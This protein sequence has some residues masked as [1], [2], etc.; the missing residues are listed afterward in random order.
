MFLYTS[1][2]L[3]KATKLVQ[4]TTP[5]AVWTDPNLDVSFSKFD[6]LLVGSGGRGSVGSGGGGNGGGGAAMFYNRSLVP[7][8]LKEQGFEINIPSIY[9]TNARFRIL[10]VES[11]I[12]GGI[13]GGD[14]SNSG[15][16]GNGYSIGKPGA[17]GGGG[18]YRT[19]RVGS[20]GGGVN[21]SGRDVNVG[22]GGLGV[23]SSNPTT[24]NQT[25]YHGGSGDVFGGG[26]GGI[27]PATTLLQIPLFALGGTGKGGDGFVDDVVHYGQG[28]GGGSYGDGGGASNPNGGYGAGGAGSTNQMHI[29]YEGG[30]G[31]AVLY[32]HS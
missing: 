23:S 7:S 11:N 31:I 8:E 9:S 13:S 27:N 15:R 30:Q 5:T 4:I 18:G 28:G 22:T 12:G 32:Y 3:T 21:D 25:S 19:Y 10:G 26:K 14:G 6:F 16:G 20:G 17:G 2:T 29:Q 24:S 1:I